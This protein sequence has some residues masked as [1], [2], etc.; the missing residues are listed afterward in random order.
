ML[1]KKVLLDSE[2][3]IVSPEKPEKKSSAP[4]KI[5][6]AFSGLAK[7]KAVGKLIKVYPPIE[8]A[9]RKTMGENGHWSFPEPL[10]KGFG[11]IYLIHDVKND[12]MYIGKKQFYGTGID[13]KGKETNWKWYVGSSDRLKDLI[14]ISGT[15]DFKFYVLE[16][17]R[18]RGG[19]GF[20]ETWSMCMAETPT[21]KKKWYNNL[22]GRVTWSTSEKITQRHKDRLHAIING[23]ALEEDQVNV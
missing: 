8:R 5:P 7:N 22:I 16:Q 4:K 1:I 18:T 14:R 10:G 23:L 21:D 11:F 13:N 15:Q 3:R 6:T 9:N 2:G 19:L 20:A 12:M 17:Y